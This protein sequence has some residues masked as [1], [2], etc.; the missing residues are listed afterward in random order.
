L[1]T[2]HELKVEIQLTELKEQLHALRNE[3]K[4]Q[5]AAD[6][7]AVK[8]ALEASKEL[9]QKH[10]DLITQMKEK[11]ATYLPKEEYRVRHEALQRRLTLVEAFQARL[12]G[13]LAVIAAVG[14]ANFIKVWTG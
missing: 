8:V 9:A 12:L 1:T 10:N 4:L 11:D 13:G 3:V 14:L 2:D 6:T 5:R 7:E